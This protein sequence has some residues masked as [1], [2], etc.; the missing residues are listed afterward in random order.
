M[1][2]FFGIEWLELLESGKYYRV[3]GARDGVVTSD[4]MAEFVS[5]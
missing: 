5:S 4:V 2:L 1:L 3:R